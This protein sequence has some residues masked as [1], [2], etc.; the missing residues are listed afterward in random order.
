MSWLVT[1]IVENEQ[2]V[3]H[4]C[5][6]KS[7]MRLFR[8]VAIGTDTFRHP[9][10][11]VFLVTAPVPHNLLRNRNVIAISEAITLDDGTHFIVDAHG[12]WL[13][14]SESNQIDAGRGFAEIDW[15]TGQAPR[16]APN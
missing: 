5:Q 1:D 12:T 9:P 2:Y 13:T 3:L 6:L 7:G 10:A 8:L 14:E 15:L 4:L 11:D 16:F